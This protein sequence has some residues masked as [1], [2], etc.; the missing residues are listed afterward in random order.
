MRHLEKRDCIKYSECWN[1]AAFAGDECVPCFKCKNNRAITIESTIGERVKKAEF[2]T[3]ERSKAIDYRETERVNVSKLMP[4]ERVKSKEVKESERVMK[5][6]VITRVE[7]AK[8]Q[9]TT[10]RKRIIIPNNYDEFVAFL[11]L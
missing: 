2:S 6:E 4:L 7:R 3:W 11:G 1:R 10:L 8:G 5:P 9:D